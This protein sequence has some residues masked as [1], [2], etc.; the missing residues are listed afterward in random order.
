MG[1]PL[2]TAIFGLGIGISL[3]GLLAHVIDIPEFA[4]ALAG[5]IGLGVGI[6]Y[7]LFIVTRYRQTLHAGVEPEEAVVTALA[8]SGRAVLF[9]GITVVIS[10]LGLF[11]IGLKFVQ[12]LAIGASVTVLVVMIASVTLLPAVLG[13]VGHAIDRLRVPGLHRDE[14]DHRAS[15]WYRWSRIIQ[16]RPITSRRSPARA[17][18]VLLALPLFSIE[19]GFTDEGNDKRGRRT[20]EAYDLLAEGFG[21]GFNGPLLLAAELDSPEQLTAFNRAIAGIQRAA[22]CR[23]SASGVPEPGSDGARSRSCSRRRRRSRPRRRT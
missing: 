15:V 6:D 10:L 7:A 9:A 22:G 12:G 13:F 2:L 21:P 19:L 20:R 16:R 1:L 18:L 11:L 5:M 23:C 8:T 17:I 4:P 3:I 14:S